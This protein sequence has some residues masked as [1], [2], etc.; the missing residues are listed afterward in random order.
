[1][2]TLLNCSSKIVIWRGQEP[3]KSFLTM[4]FGGPKPLHRKGTML[5]S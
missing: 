3:K 5:R 4:V 1:L 2:M